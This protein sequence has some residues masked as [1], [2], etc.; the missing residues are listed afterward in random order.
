MHT[1]MLSRSILFF[2]CIICVRS[3]YGQTSDTIELRWKGRI[4]L[5][6][7]GKPFW[8][9]DTIVDETTQVI[10]DG[11]DASGTLLFKAK[12]ILSV[13]SSD[14]ARE[15]VEGKDWVYRRGR[16]YL[17]ADSAIPFIKKEDLVYTVNKPGRSMTGS[18]PG[19]FVLFSESP[20]F[21]SM[22]VAVSYIPAHRGAWKGPVPKAAKREL[23][24][25]FSKLTNKENVKVVFY[26]NSIEVGYNSSGF[27][28]RAPYVPSWPEMIVHR[29]RAAYGPQIGFLNPSVAGKLAQWGKD[30]ATNRVLPAHPDLVII[31]FGMNDG[32][33][34]ISPDKYRE[35]INGIIATVTAQNPQAEFILIAPMLPNPSAVQNG[36]Q[37][38]YKK[39]LDKLAK[40][41]IVVADMTGV[42][43]ELLKHKSYQ[44]M[45][46]NNVNHPNDYLARWYAQYI[47][48]L[49]RP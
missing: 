32:S 39:E 44:D 43:A 11:N 15:F 16:I 35:D 42:H 12:K 38:L 27:L 45:T 28:N 34:K 31:G 40:K 25:T 5:A 20:Y 9:A 46:G 1:A 37:A 33:A 18:Q 8:L 26:G 23:P 21:I 6:E 41:G 17:L 22:Q 14:H 49:L 10:K 4:D 3:S 47:T 29:L 2:C 30:E 7:Y 13:R 24:N 48:G 36:I 19:T